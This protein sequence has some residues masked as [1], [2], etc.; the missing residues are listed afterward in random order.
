M[1]FTAHLDTF[2]R[3]HLP[4]PEQQPEFRFDLPELRFP[5]RLNCATE[6]LDRH[7]R[8]GRGSRRCVSA[9]GGPSWTY[10][11]LQ[12]QADAIAHVLVE[13]CGLVPGNRVL[14]RAANKPMLVACWFA[15]MKAGGIAVATMP[16]LRAKELGQVIDKARVGIALCDVAL[17]GELDAA[18]AAAAS[19][20]EGPAAAA[21]LSRI[22]CFGEPSA[23]DGLEARMARHAGKPFATV[24]TAADDTCLLAFTS[25][26]TGQPKAT[27]H[28]HRDVM[29]SCVCFPPHVLRAG[30]DDVFIGS[31]PLAFTFGLGGLTVFPMHIGASTVLLE[32]AGP[33]DLLEAI[34]ANQATVCFTAPTS[35]RA[36]AAGAREK[37]IGSRDGGRLRKCVA[38]GEALPAAP[39]ALW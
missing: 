33:P 8:E 35:Y 20:P 36:M 29:A 24:D 7:V 28:F 39:R 1:K 13:D 32:K 15:V 2:A 18:A 27:M 23:A 14:L 10:A 26:T 11:E 22:V 31:P 38:A 6:L 9:P 34:V 17:R 37:K 4:P 25:G 5:E 12:R 30:P 16:M 21:R 19:V 3:D